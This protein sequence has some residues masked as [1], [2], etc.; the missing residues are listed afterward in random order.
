MEKN[1]E[2]G[3]NF[4]NVTRFHM[5]SAWWLSTTLFADISTVILH[6]IF[7]AFNDILSSSRTR[8]FLLHEHHFF[9][10]HM[11]L[12]TNDR[13]PTAVT[14]ILIFLSSVYYFI[15]NFISFL[16]FLCTSLSCLQFIFNETSFFQ[17]LSSVHVNYYVALVLLILLI[18]LIFVHQNVC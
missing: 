6:V 8:P 10:R 2:P 12:L 5:L 16:I 14:V 3:Y 15:D 7:N 9:Q 13:Q 1:Y 18:L 4:L 17:K 11:L